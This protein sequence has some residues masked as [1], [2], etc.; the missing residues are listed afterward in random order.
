MRGT[1]PRIA[2]SGVDFARMR[3]LTEMREWSP[4]PNPHPFSNRQPPKESNL[5]EIGRISK[6]RRVKVSGD[7]CIPNPRQLLSFNPILKYNR[8]HAVPMCVLNACLNT[9]GVCSLFHQC[10][11]NTVLSHLSQSS[12][13]SE[14]W[15]SYHGDALP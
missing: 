9:W 3:F 2:K 12:G 6:G 8:K 10:F 5:F 4:P 1:Y 14:F 11:H 7:K 15:H 13:C